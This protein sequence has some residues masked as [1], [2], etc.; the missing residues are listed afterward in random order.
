V[1]HI[2]APH[3]G[4][5]IAL[6]GRLIPTIQPHGLR[7]EH[8]IR[9]GAPTPPTSTSFSQY[10]KASISNIELNDQLGCCV[11]SGRAHRIGLLT[12]AATAGKPFVYS[13]QQIITE[14]ERVGGFDPNNPE[15]TDNG[16]DMTV[17]ANDGVQNGYADGSKDA[18]WVFV[19]ASKKSQVMLAFWLVEN[20]DLGLALPD[21]WISP[22]PSA[23]GF[24][25]DVAGDPDYSNGHCV[26][27]IDYDANHGVLIA[28]WGLTGWIT[29]AALAKYA[30]TSGG[31][32]LIAH[33]NHDQLAKAAQKAPN[34]ID[35]STIITFFDQ[36]LGGSVAIPPA[37]TPTPPPPL[38]PIP[39]PPAKGVTL[40]QAQQWAAAGLAEKWPKLGDVDDRFDD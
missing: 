12:G 23:N 28:T 15:A 5:E 17:A 19:D 7:F 30:V 22:F 32:E 21:D 2:Y 35:W 26:E 9:D 40:A 8:L 20:G 39:A 38:P 36:S 4:R 34:G 33:V 11:I 1:K 29:W 14:Y 18:G 31:G 10:A 37:P 16:C 25:W 24:V 27:I 6:G 3:L 13:S